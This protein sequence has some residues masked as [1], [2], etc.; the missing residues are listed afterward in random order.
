MNDFGDSDSC[1]DAGVAQKINDRKIEVLTR[2][3]IP[4][5]ERMHQGVWA[6]GAYEPALSVRDCGDEASGIQRLEGHGRHS[7]TDEFRD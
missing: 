6:I 2:P 3:D 7:L 5:A 1:S 4:D